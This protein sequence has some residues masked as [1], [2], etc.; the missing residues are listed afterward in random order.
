MHRKI[1]KDRAC[2]SGDILPDRQTD[3]HT[4]TDVLIAVY[5][6]TAPA[7]EVT[8]QR[9]IQRGRIEQP[10]HPVYETWRATLAKRMTFKPVCNVGEL[11]RKIYSPSTMYT[12]RLLATL[13]IQIQSYNIPKGTKL[14]AMKKQ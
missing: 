14:Y 5:F 11:K 7:G 3:I 12:G 2:G 1:S 10:S 8:S 9:P 4:Y 6:V 13:N